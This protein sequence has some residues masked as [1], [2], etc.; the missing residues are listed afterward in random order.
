VLAGRVVCQSRRNSHGEDLALFRHVGISTF[1]DREWGDVHGR[2][3]RELTSSSRAKTS[4]VMLDMHA[5]DSLPLVRN[6]NVPRAKL[7]SKGQ[8]TI[9]MVVRERLGVRQGDAIDFVF[10]EDGSISVRSVKNDLLALEGLLARPGTR[11]VSLEEMD[12]A[13]AGTAVKRH[14]RSTVRKPWRARR[15]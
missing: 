3:A 15:S 6:K 11:T 9:P 2:M 7:T 10:L 12:A 4:K 5:H 8:T 13:I 14:R 1:T